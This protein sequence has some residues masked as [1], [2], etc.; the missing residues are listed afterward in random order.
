MNSWSNELLTDVT[1]QSFKSYSIIQ[2]QILISPR[3]PQFS[4]INSNQ[5]IIF[6]IRSCERSYRQ[7]ESMVVLTVFFSF[8]MVAVIKEGGREWS[9]FV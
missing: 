6:L 1:S 2:C 4:M 8:L 7:S 5:S 3:Y 9:I